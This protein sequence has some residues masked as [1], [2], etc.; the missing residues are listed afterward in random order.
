MPDKK[1]PTKMV[2]RNRNRS[3]KK[4]QQY[5]DKWKKEGKSEDWLKTYA[6]KWRYEDAKKEKEELK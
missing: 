3:E 1:I 5:L 4:L 2:I 6:N